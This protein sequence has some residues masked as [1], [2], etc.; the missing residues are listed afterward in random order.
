[1]ESSW[2]WAASMWVIIII[3]IIDIIIIT[4]IITIIITDLGGSA[5]QG[6]G[7][8][9]LACWNYG[10]ESLRGHGYL[11]PVNVLCC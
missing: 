8:R 5:V 3:I 1:M 9:P 6:M 10:L 4:D 7:L 2:A 11:C